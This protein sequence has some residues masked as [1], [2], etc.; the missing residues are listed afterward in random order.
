M[1]TAQAAVQALG[2]FLPLAYFA[3]AF[4]YA[5]HFGGRGAPSVV[6]P[7]RLALGLA[8]VLHLA[9]AGARWLQAAAFPVQ[10]PWSTLSGIALVMVL[11]HLAA[12]AAPPRGEAGRSADQLDPEGRGQGRS[13]AGSG[14]LVLGTSGLLQ[15]LASAFAPLLPPAASPGPEAFKVFHVVT[16]LVAAGALVLSGIHGWLYLVVYRRIRRHR[17]GALVRG[18]PSLRHL[19]VMMR[20]SALVGFALLTIGL[21]VGIAWAHYDRL[22]SFHYSDPWVL[23]M[24]AIWIHFGFVA[25]SGRIPGL[26]ARRASL[27]AALGLAVFLSAGALTLI[28]DLTFHWRP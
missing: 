26:T 13:A 14:A 8:L 10:D 2:T 18:L 20:R 7:R 1:S 16:S 19:A 25:F 24:L 5:M 6:G 23:A 28:P 4:L 12:S 27:A 17:F 21:N 22:Q 11:L 15:A 3:A 9:L